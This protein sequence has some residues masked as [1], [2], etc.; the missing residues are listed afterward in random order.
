M[1]DIASWF[2]ARDWLRQFADKVSLSPMYFL[3]G[4]LALLAVIAL[5]GS[6]PVN[7]LKND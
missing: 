1:G 5:T 4:D 2:I 3:A 7:F 6:N